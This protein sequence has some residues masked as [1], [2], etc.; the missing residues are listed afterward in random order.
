MGHSNSPVS[1]TVVSTEYLS[2]HSTCVTFISHMK[3][4]RSKTNGESVIGEKEPKETEKK[5]K[6]NEKN[7]AQKNDTRL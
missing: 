6:R 5:L 2:T 3:K 7:L 1:C 4:K